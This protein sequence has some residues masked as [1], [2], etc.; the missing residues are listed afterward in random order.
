MSFVF[1]R[2]IVSLLIIIVGL[3]LLTGCG[4]V[5]AGEETLNEPMAKPETNGEGIEYD[6][7]IYIGELKDGEWNGQGTF[8]DVDG[9]VVSGHWENGEYIGPCI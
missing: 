6:G 3:V 4:W 2:I 5:R 8:T 7:G 9:T 1:K